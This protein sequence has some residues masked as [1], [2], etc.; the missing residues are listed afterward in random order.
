MVNG[1]QF[2]EVY[3]GFFAFGSPPGRFSC[4]PHATTTGGTGRFSG[5]TNVLFNGASASFTNAL[6]NN[7]DL[8][9]TAVVPP[10]AISGPI[11]IFTPHGN[12][13]STALFQV[14]PP[15]LTIRVT[16]ASEL[17]IIWPATSPEFVLEESENLLA[18]TWTPIT[19]IPVR[20]NGQSKLML[21]A[22]T[23]KRFY[24]LKKN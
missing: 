2:T 5:A 15:P 22:P 3:S 4:V 7:F 21:N 24:R 16:S 13:T 17:E 14:L 23:G 6:T 19:Q 12:V 8:R 9:I 18:G 1:D 11:T 20:A 10:D